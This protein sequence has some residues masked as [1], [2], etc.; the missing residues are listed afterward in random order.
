M[1]TPSNNDKQ[2]FKDFVQKIGYEFDENTL[3]NFELKFQK[4]Y[5]F[6]PELAIFAGSYLVRKTTQ[7]VTHPPKKSKTI[8]GSSFTISSIHIRAHRAKKNNFPL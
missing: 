7:R 6:L 3:E 2:L 4:A 1:N 8:S 5:T